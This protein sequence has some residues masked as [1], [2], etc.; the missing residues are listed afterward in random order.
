MTHVNR[1]HPHAKHLDGFIRYSSLL[2]RLR[3]GTQSANRAVV[4]V[5]DKYGTGFTRFSSATSRR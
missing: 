3:T 2:K 5:G 1:L 4:R